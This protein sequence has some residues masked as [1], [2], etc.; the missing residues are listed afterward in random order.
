MDF[1][2]RLQHGFLSLCCLLALAT[3]LALARGLVPRGADF[4]LWYR[5]HQ[6]TGQAAGL[7]LAYHLVYLVVRGYVEGLNMSSFPLAWRRSDLDELKLQAGFVLGRR[8]TLPEAGVFRPAQK[9]LYWGTGL[10]LTMLVLTGLLVGR[11]ESFGGPGLLPYLSFSAN[12]HRG[13]S[14]FLLAVFLWHLYGVLTWRGSWAPQWSWITGSL[15]EDLAKAMVPGHYQKVLRREE[16]RLASISRKTKEE[17]AEEEWR[18]EKEAVEEDLE[19]G[20]RL[21]REEKFVDA[22]FHY[23]RALERY[24]G[25]SQAHYNMAIVLRKMGERRMAVESFRRFVEE[26]PFHPLASKAQEHIV[27][28]EKEGGE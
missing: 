10:I 20:N 13:F 24:P 22:L 28:I 1:H 5:I 17:Q 19:A 23:R 3:G 12:I 15:R 16:E 26:D 8:E 7:L 18:L 4:D 6:W 14:L 11:W 9:A 21:A 27:E 25:Y 2:L